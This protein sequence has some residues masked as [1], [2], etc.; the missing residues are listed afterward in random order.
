MNLKESLKLEV[1][2]IN[3]NNS[4]GQILIYVWAFEQERKF[5]TQDVFVPWH[6]HDTY[7]KEVEQKDRKQVNIES[8]TGYIETAIKDETKKSTIYHRYYH[9]FKKGEL[10]ELIAEV[11][12]LEIR[13]SFYDHANWCVILEKTE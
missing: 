11:P 9:V 3:F 7:E 12:G 2:C 6:L 13:R 4:I 8:N 1:F 10:E 5:A